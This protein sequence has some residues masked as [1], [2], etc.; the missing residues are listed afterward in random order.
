MD[1]SLRHLYRLAITCGEKAIERYRQGRLRSGYLLNCSMC[2][3]PF[4]K[5]KCQYEADP[6]NNVLCADCINT[7][8]ECSKVLCEDH[9]H[10]CSDCSDVGCVPDGS[11]DRG[12]WPD[13]LAC[14]DRC[15]SLV[16]LDHI[17]ICE[18]WVYDGFEGPEEFLGCYGNFCAGCNDRHDCRD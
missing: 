8:G 9:A 12:C 2:D 11:G 17:W 3:S 7:C 16:C 14:C 5:D 18:T 13:G 6:C 10:V 4:V 1:K 15:N